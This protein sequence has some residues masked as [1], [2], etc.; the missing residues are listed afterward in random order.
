MTLSPTSAPA[1]MAR[2]SVAPAATRLAFIATTDRYRELAADGTVAADVA[3]LLSNERAAWRALSYGEAE[4]GAP[5]AS[6][7]DTGACIAPLSTCA[8]CRS[9]PLGPRTYGAALATVRTPANARVRQAFP[10]ALG[11][12]MNAGYRTPC[13]AS[14]SVGASLMRAAY[15]AIL[16]GE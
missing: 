7:R 16:A 9:L 4:N 14:F 6:G 8:D 2:A 5:D 10:E 3:C 15:R 12:V 11:N 13:C 1:F